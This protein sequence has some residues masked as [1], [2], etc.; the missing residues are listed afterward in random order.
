MSDILS[1]ASFIFVSRI[2][3]IINKSLICYLFSL[4]RLIKTAV[5]AAIG[6]II[7]TVGIDSIFWNK[8]VWPEAEVFWFN[9]V[10]NKSSEWGVS[11]FFW[12]FYSALPKAMGL[13]IFLIPFGLLWESRV[14]VLVI[15]ALI[16]VLIFSFLPHKELRFIIYVFP[17]LNIAAAAACDRLWNNRSKSLF[18]GILATGA[19]G[20]LI[21]NVILSLF[22]LI[23]SNTNYPG[24]VAISRLVFLLN[25]VVRFFIFCCFLGFIDLLLLTQMFLYI[26]II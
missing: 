1:S 23:V 3:I 17:I 12:Y 2:K 14:R 4:S 24:G 9:T 8:P 7:L 15:P 16:F 22:L 25:F 10:L 26:L 5:P 21:L 6:L 20:H 13:S 19:V 18:Q 11:P